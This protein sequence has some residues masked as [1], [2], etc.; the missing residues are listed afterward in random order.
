MKTSVFFFFF[1]VV[2]ALAG[3]QSDKPSEEWVDLFDGKT[4]EGW[5]VSSENPE[6]ITV[7]DGAIKC[8]GERAHLFYGVD[9]TD[10]EFEAE[11]KTSE[12]S[13]SGIFIHT[14]YQAEGWPQQGYEIQVNNS[15]RGSVNHPER[16]KTG[17]VYNVRNIYYPLVDDKEWF[18][19]RVK[20]AGNLVEVFV[21][22]V[23][24]NE[25]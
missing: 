16:R 18:T 15:Y 12:N 9:Y 14:G 11:V 2:A 13:N 24:V 25:Y 7:E 6:S 3:C 19:M 23:K 10:F 5:K 22:D 17:S 1:L 20:V 21:N 8:A 4:L